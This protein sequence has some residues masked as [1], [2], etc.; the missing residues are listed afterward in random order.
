MIVD[1]RT[2]DITLIRLFLD[3]VSLRARR[4]T[5]LQRGMQCMQPAVYAQVARLRGEAERLTS[6]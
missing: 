1:N 6:R 3:H 2:C 4:E 5:R